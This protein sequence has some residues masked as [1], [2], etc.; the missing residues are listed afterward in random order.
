V[1]LV[2]AG[3]EGLIINGYI[4]ASIQTDRYDSQSQYEFVSCPNGVA[5][6]WKSFKQEMV[7]NSTIEIEYIVTL[8]AAKEVVWIIKFDFELSV[9]WSVSNPWNLCCDNNGAIA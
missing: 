5:I 9:V 6:S 3:E 7:P 8:E 4:N 2:Y 1:F